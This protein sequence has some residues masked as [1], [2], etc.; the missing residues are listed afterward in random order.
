MGTEECA[1]PVFLS[2]LDCARG[3]FDDFADDL[4]PGPNV[5]GACHDY[6]KGAASSVRIIGMLA[7]A[8]GNFPT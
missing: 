8:G 2:R 4:A 3:I 7:I 6:F 1:G 5:I